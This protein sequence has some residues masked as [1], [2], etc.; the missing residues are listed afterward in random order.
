MVV[1]PA[2]SPTAAVVVEVRVTPV[3]RTP[4]EQVPEADG[5]RFGLRTAPKLPLLAAGLVVDGKVVEVP[6]E[7]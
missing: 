1:T 5:Q 4:I 7:V 2:A 6:V 3:M